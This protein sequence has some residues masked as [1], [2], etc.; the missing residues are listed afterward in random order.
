MQSGLE[1]AIAC[2]AYLLAQCLTAT[3]PAAPVRRSVMYLYVYV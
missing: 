3:A 1:N 2:K